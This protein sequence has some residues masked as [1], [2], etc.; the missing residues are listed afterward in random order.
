VRARIVPNSLVCF[1]GPESLTGPRTAL[2]F[3]QRAVWYFLTFVLVYDARLE[4]GQ[5]VEGPPQ[6]LHAAERDVVHGFLRLFVSHLKKFP[7]SRRM[8]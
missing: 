7:G 5:D 6:G 8:C 2:H 3:M 1:A 4:A